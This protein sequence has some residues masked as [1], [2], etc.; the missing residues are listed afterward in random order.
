[1]QLRRRDLGVVL[2]ECEAAQLQAQAAREQRDERRAWRARQTEREV[3]ERGLELLDPFIDEPRAQELL[4]R[5]G[6]QSDLLVAGRAVGGGA[7][8]GGSGGTA[9]G[10]RERLGVAHRE[11]LAPAGR[12]ELERERVRDRAARSNA[13]LCSARSAARSA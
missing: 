1:M 3:C 8:C 5:A 4:G 2:G 12:R 11:V 9:P 10:V 6:A 13:S 7:E